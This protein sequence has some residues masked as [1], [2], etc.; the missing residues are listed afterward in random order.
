MIRKSIILFTSSFPFGKGEQFIE[1][2]LRFLSEGFSKVY[3]FPYY[4]G[5]NTKLRI[6][7]PSNVTVFTPFRDEKFTFFKLLVKG[8][9]NNRVLFPYFRELVNYPNI[10]IKPWHFSLWFRSM[11]NCRMILNDKRLKKCIKEEKSNAVFYFYW[12]NRPLGIIAGIRK[13]SRLLVSR[14]HGSDLYK[15]IPVN[16]NYIPFQDFALK[17]LSNI[18]CISNHGADYLKNRVKGLSPKIS[19]HRLGTLDWGGSSW[20]PSEKLRIIS[21]STVDK[22]K[23]VALIAEA[24][25]YIKIPVE[26]THIGDGPLMK[27]LK[28]N[29]SSFDG[30][31]VSINLKG[32]ITN[33]EVHQLYREQPFDLFVN[34][35]SSEGVPFSI[36]EALSHSFPVMATAAGGTS[37][38][39][40][41]SCGMLL[42]VDLTAELLSEHL[43]SFHALSIEKKVEL[44]VNAR[45]RWEECGSAEINYSKFIAFL[46]KLG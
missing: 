25:T 37:E 41:E 32:R 17:E 20:K 35:S 15:E 44:R 6:H 33:E 42:P 16:R 27:E 28:L 43:T 22:N 9:F 21:C 29:C 19:V 8:I 12:G 13:I 10:L 1:T 2:E 7:P 40:D 45:N 38:I 24:L 39:V 46:Q 11:L 5:G 36:V 34:V 18:I 30:S 3:I 14:F 4:Y 26:W 23:R 31:F